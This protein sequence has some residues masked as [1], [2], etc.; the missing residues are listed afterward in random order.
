MKYRK[1]CSPCMNYVSDHP[2]DCRCVCHLHEAMDE[3]RKNL[4][5]MGRKM[6]MLKNA[7]ID[8]EFNQML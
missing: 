3:L 1:L 6:E 7:L 8:I 2:N 5:L 4:R